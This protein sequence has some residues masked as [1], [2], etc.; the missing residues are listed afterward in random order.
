[1]ERRG[2]LGWRQGVHRACLEAWKGPGPLGLE[3][4]ALGEGA[5]GGKWC[6]Q[7]CEDLAQ[8][9]CKTRRGF[10]RSSGPGVAR[11]WGVA[12]RPGRGWG[13]KDMATISVL[14]AVEV[15]PCGFI[16]VR[17][18]SFLHGTGEGFRFLLFLRYTLLFF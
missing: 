3:S 2:M 14:D 12:A 1:M 18:P 15:Q 7:V 10:A 6:D 16:S 4:A 9:P 11:P 17:L 5:R 8:E 13:F